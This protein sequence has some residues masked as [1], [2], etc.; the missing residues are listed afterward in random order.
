MS[1][2]S[3]ENKSKGACK[4]YQNWKVMIMIDYYDYDYDVVLDLLESLF[5]NRKNKYIVS[6]MTHMNFI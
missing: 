2:W 4:F 3:I 6:R 1:F 5:I